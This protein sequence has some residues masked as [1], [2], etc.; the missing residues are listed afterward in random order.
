MLSAIEL[1]NNPDFKYREDALLFLLYMHGN[2]CFYLNYSNIINTHL[3]YM[4]N[5]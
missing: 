3:I 1:Y 2:S 5:T 4:Q